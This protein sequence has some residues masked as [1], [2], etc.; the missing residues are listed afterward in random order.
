VEAVFAGR[1]TSHSARDPDARFVARLGEIQDT[2][3]TLT[4][5]NDGTSVHDRRTLS[6]GCSSH[7]EEEGKDE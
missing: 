1:E 5:G 2:T 4:T 6:V 7:H 3:D